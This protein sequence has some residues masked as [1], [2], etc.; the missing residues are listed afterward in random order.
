MSS[1]ILPQI[2]RKVLL[3]NHLMEPAELEFVFETAAR[4]GLS[5]QEVLLNNGYF[6]PQEFSLIEKISKAHKKEFLLADRYELL[7]KIGQG[8]MGQVFKARDIRR[9]EIVAIKI[10]DESLSN[11]M[12][13]VARFKREAEYS[14]RLR[15]PNI[16]GA[17][18]M[19]TDGDS[20]Y[21]VMEY[22]DGIPLSEILR[23]EGKLEESEALDIVDQLCFALDYMYQNGFIHRDIKPD[24]IL[25]LPDGQVKLIDMGLVRS[26]DE[27]SLTLTGSVLG[28]PHYISPEQA[29]GKKELDIRTDIYSLGATFYHM[30]TGRTPFEGENALEVLNHHIHSTPP[31]PLEINPNLN[32]RIVQLVLWMMEKKRNKRPATP[33]DV[34]EAIEKIRRKSRFSLLGKSRKKEGYMPTKYFYS[35]KTQT[36]YIKL[37]LPK[38]VLLF[39]VLFLILATTG[40]VFLWKEVRSQFMPPLVPPDER[41]AKDLLTTLEKA[42][43]GHQY[44]KTFHLLKEL[45]LK[46][47]HTQTFISHKIQLARWKEKLVEDILDHLDIVDLSQILPLGGKLKKEMKTQYVLEYVFSKSKAWKDWKIEKMPKGK[48][49]PPFPSLKKE[50]IRMSCGIPFSEISNLQIHWT[51]AKKEIFH[52]QV[53]TLQILNYGPKKTI[54]LWKGAFGLPLWKDWKPQ[55]PFPFASKEGSINAL[56]PEILNLDILELGRKIQVKLSLQNS[57]LQ[58]NPELKADKHDKKGWHGGNQPK[59]IA[60]YMEPKGEKRFK[61]IILHGVISPQ[62]IVQNLKK[63]MKKWD[64]K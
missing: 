5:P 60:L 2:L 23:R 29:S 45:Y 40:G 39:Y 54:L 59:W 30:I 18:D 3:E 58:W 35:T 47:P 22:I 19:G 62:W 24:N 34:H 12:D 15:H 28:T 27:S 61:K 31:H 63:E 36:G 25:L 8:G 16:A 10:L 6:T 44:E 42:F 52:I 55:L 53:G 4:T 41:E 17:L 1:P 11:D 13:F 26:A 49:M 37:Y 43:Y 14:Y 9:D 64:V 20:H 57:L 46:Y 38:K 7:G 56:V 32:K 51:P 50:L 21:L 33:L 48:T